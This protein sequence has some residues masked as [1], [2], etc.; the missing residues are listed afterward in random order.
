MSEKETNSPIEIRTGQCR[1]II[2]SQ[3]EASKTKRGKRKMPQYTT[4]KINSSKA[5][6]LLHGFM[7]DGSLNQQE[8]DFKN[9]K[10]SVAE[11]IYAGDAIPAAD[12]MQEL[13]EKA[14]Q[15]VMCA[16]KLIADDNKSLVT[17]ALMPGTEGNVRIIAGIYDENSRDNANRLL[18][19]LGV[20]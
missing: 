20:A 3:K 14:G 1:R 6:E 9:N 10:I 11:H 18:E 17:I 7:T 15:S 2:K 16:G 13:F 8:T 19:R 12:K 5:G 4:S